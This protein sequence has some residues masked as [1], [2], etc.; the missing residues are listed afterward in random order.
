[1]SR[2]EHADD[3]G[4]RLHGRNELISRADD[5]SGLLQVRIDL[6]RGG[7]EGGS[8]ECEAAAWGL[9]VVRAAVIV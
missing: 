4:I 9:S 6:L 7:V 2:R 3:V 8:S 5:K 1:M